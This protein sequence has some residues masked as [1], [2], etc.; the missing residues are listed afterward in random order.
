MK[1]IFLHGK[2]VCLPLRKSRDEFSGG[3]SLVRS[4]L[5]FVTEMNDR[6]QILE[7]RGLEKS[8]LQF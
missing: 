1:V 3:G 2:L 5:S 8:S 7:M 6:V 4:L